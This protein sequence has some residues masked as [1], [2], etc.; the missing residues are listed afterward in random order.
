VLRNDATADTVRQVL[1]RSHTPRR[2]GLSVTWWG[3]PG[4]LPVVGGVIEM[5]RRSYGWGA[6]TVLVG[7]S[8]LRTAIR[9]YRSGFPL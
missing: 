9:R 8:L 1:G 4:L 6:L 5:A 2:A 7:A 3:V